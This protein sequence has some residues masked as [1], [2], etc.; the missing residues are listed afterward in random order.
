MLAG[1]LGC[2]LPDAWDAQV[3]IRKGTGREP[4][5][6]ADRAALGDRAGRFPLFG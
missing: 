1:L 5:T 6:A 3:A 2:P 4:L